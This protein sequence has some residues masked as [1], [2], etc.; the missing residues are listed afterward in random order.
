MPSRASP[1]LP[2]AAAAERQEA[3]S[4]PSPP[5][6]PFLRLSLALKPSRRTGSEGIKRSAARSASTRACASSSA[7]AA[8]GCASHARAS[9]WRGA[10]AAAAA[11]PER[12]KL[13]V[14]LLL[15]RPLSRGASRRPRA[16]SAAGRSS[17]FCPALPRGVSGGSGK[18]ERGQQEKRASWGKRW[19]LLRA[20]WP[21]SSLPGSPRRPAG[22]LGD[23]FFLCVK[24]NRENSPDVSAAS[25]FSRF[26]FRGH[27]LFLLVLLICLEEGDA[28]SV[29]LLASEERKRRPSQSGE[30][31][32][33]DS[34]RAKKKI[35]GAASGKRQ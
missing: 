11:L 26:S 8:T 29:S 35:D 13:L 33:E 22:P 30:P 24:R 7:G 16:R 32:K 15:L 9:S 10:A 34:R 25:V 31:E 12:L 21:A 2:P 6:C 17:T 5:R 18:A 20:P 4:S 27:S 3:S 28:R 23:V 1:W 14:L 19:R